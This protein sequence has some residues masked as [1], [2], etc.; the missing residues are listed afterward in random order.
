MA[1]ETSS[2]LLINYYYCVFI[3]PS[4]RNFWKFID[5]RLFS[6]QQFM[7][8]DWEI[9]FLKYQIVQGLCFSR[10]IGSGRKVWLFSF[11]S[12]FRSIENPAIGALLA[13]YPC[14]VE[15]IANPFQCLALKKQFPAWTERDDLEPYR[16]RRSWL[17]ILWLLC[18]CVVSELISYSLCLSYLSCFVVREL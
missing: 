8:M 16:W 14:S 13:W 5:G 12:L 18:L 1:L 4:E 17:F 15:Q 11:S 7:F 10:V 3:P 9:I 2:I 6:K